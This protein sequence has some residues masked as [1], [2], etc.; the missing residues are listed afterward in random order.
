MDLV[1]ESDDTACTP[2]RIGVIVL[3]PKPRPLRDH[4]TEVA[5]T[6]ESTMRKTH[7]INMAVRTPFDDLNLTCYSHVVPESERMLLEF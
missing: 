6:Q 5:S 7:L 4:G 3:P 1:K 2:Q